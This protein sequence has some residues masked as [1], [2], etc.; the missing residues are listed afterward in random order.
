LIFRQ[1]SNHEY[2]LS[3]LLKKEKQFSTLFSDKKMNEEQQSFFFWHLP[4]SFSQAETLVW[5]QTVHKGAHKSISSDFQGLDGR[6]LN[7]L[8]RYDLLKKNSNP[9]KQR[10][11]LLLFETLH[12]S[13]LQPV[14]LTIDEVRK[15]NMYNLP[16]RD[17]ELLLSDK[18]LPASTRS[19]CQQLL[20]ICQLNSRDHSKIIRDTYSQEEFQSL[21]NDHLDETIQ[22]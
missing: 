13:S 10:Q 15:K 6:T 3:F 8:T 22:G 19:T 20:S 1:T 4:D 2:Y 11:F 7:N 18:N 16:I 12:P 14:S 17:L 5:L 21:L 9:E